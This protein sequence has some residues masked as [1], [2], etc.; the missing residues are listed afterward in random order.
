[1]NIPNNIPLNGGI[2]AT[3]GSS[4]DVDVIGDIIVMAKCFNQAKVSPEIG[5]PRRAAKIG[6]KSRDPP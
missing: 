5:L 3:G 1:M 4:D 2:N 6:K